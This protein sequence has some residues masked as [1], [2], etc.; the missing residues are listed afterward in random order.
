MAL[1]ETYNSGDFQNWRFSKLEI[2]IWR[3]FKSGQKKIFKTVLKIPVHYNA[4]YSGVRLPG[5]TPKNILS[6]KNPRVCLYNTN[7][8][9][10][11]PFE[12]QFSENELILID[13]ILFHIFGLCPYRRTPLYSV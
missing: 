1:C 5:Q 13:G 2:Q 12:I 11:K 8:I 9:F 4:L 7:I 3:I 6:C 10:A